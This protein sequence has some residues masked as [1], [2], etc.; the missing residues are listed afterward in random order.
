M[1]SVKA[2]RGGMFD[3]KMMRGNNHATHKSENRYSSSSSYKGG[4]SECG[5][6]TAATNN[7]SGTVNASG[8]DSNRPNKKQAAFDNFTNDNN[9]LT[10]DTGTLLIRRIYG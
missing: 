1:A 10:D 8:S 9:Q 2:R 6:N 5:Y 7:N 3:R 4:S